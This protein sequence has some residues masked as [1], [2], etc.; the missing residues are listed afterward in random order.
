VRIR[1]IDTLIALHLTA[2]KINYEF[3]LK[4][5][6]FVLYCALLI[7]CEC[8]LQIVSVENVM[9]IPADKYAHHTL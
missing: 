3:I 2:G 9:F 6:L 5:S 8:M 4:D 1:N 7:L